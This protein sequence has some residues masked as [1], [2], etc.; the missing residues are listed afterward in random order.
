MKRRQY[1]ASA[2]VGLGTSVAGCTSGGDGPQEQAQPTATATTT[3][4]ATESPTESPTPTA[5]ESPTDTPEP[6]SFELVSFEL[7]EHA[8][9]GAE[10]R[11]TFTVKNTGE[12]EGEFSTT[13]SVTTS[14][15]DEWSTPSD[16]WT[17]TIGAG[18]EFTFE[19]QTWTSQYMRSTT[20]RLDEFDATKTIQWVSKKLEF[21]DVYETPEGIE[22]SVYDKETPE[23]YLHE[24][25]GYTYEERAKEGHTWLFVYVRVK[26]ATG[27]PEYVPTASDFVVV[28]D[29]SQYDRVYEDDVTSEDGDAYE[30]G[31]LQ[32]GVVRDGWILYEV[33]DKYKQAKFSVVWSESYYDGDVAVHWESR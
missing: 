29:N 21:D 13:V 6:A 11:F 5:T 22:L 2:A 17:E 30:G 3:A 15:T 25:A 27:S 14:E 9:I 8:E 1:L 16:P 12:V 10:S 20:I 7:P 33:P 32:P 4:T 23:S 19:S 28:A 18:E 26:N 31:D 24:Y